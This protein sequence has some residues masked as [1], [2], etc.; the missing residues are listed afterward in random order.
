MSSKPFEL[1]TSF[2]QNRELSWL[3]FNE[4]VLAEAADATVPLFE[5]LKFAAIFTS[6]LDE[7]FMIRVGSLFDLSLLKQ[8]HIDNKTGMTPEE[9]LHAVY[10]AVAPLYKRR[11]KVMEEIEEQ[12]RLHDISRV[13]MRELIVSEQKYVEN[14]YQNTIRPMLSPQVVDTSHPF[15]HLI[16]KARYIAVR[17]RAKG[18]EKEQ[19]GLIPVPEA[20]PRT[21]F[22]PGSAVRYLLTE[23]ILLAY[24]EDVFSMYTVCDKAVIC[25]TRNAD[26][27]PDDEN[28]EVDD[29]YRRHMKRVIKK[30]ARLA[31]V[32]LELFGGEVS[33]EL[34]EFLMR[35]LALKK[36]Q[37]FKSKTPLDLSYV[38]GLSERMTPAARK[39]MT[40]R[41]FK[42]MP[43]AMVNPNESV[44]KQVMK[45]DLFLSYPYESMEPFL[46]LVEEAAVDPAVVSIKITIY[47]L[48]SS[49]RLVEALT[50]ASENGKDV[51][52][53]LELRARFDEQNNINWSETLEDAGCQVLYGM[54][55]YKVH[56]KI[57][58]I[59]R[60]EKGKVQYITQIGTGNYNEKTAKLYTDFCLMT[61]D[62]E[63]GQDASEFFK[64]MALS[65]LDGEYHALMVAPNAMQSRIIEKIDEMIAVAAAGGNAHMMIKTNSV[66]D[67]VL[68]DRL[69]AASDAGVKIEMVVRG[70]C[71]ILPQIPSK[72]ENITVTSV[73]GR[74]L[75]HSRVYCFMANGES[76]VY[77]SSADFMTR[78]MTRRVEI[79]CPVKS[80]QVKQRIIDFMLTMLHDN[81]KARRLMRDGS[82]L[83]VSNGEAPLS[84]QDAFMIEAEEAA[85]HAAVK[86]HGVWQKMT[87]R[88]R[89][90]KQQ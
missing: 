51:V 11:D 89:K 55:D 1:D 80:Q 39:S 21:V 50:K 58:L 24:A 71:C 46:K 75:E 67:R 64:N 88:F 57:C 84:C 35:Q 48:A 22:L 6:N 83:P 37:V 54:E 60:Q 38:Y 42:P 79:A 78:N 87:A 53:L 77:I 49:S 31:C 18:K 85:S 59:T 61:S 43:S 86:P 74:F 27:N 47:R 52:A 29:D 65:N 13:Q 70:I 62:M 16:N 69:Q 10:D 17:L 2:T 7:F 4:R 56:S 36:E 44:T 25:V 20:L 63:I 5:R 33:T 23:Q 15:P 81:V 72:T 76:E 26:I 12:L 9:Q 3:R 32:R 66:T 90:K 82:Y 19:F 45:R 8:V 41:P 34:R 68:I 73:V 28:F 40:Y 30:R 14:Y